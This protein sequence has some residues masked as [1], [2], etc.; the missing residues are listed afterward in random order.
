LFL[1]CRLAACKID[2]MAPTTTQLTLPEIVLRK[3][4][5]AIVSVFSGLSLVPVL[6]WLF[7]RFEW[8]INAVHWAATAAVVALCWLHVLRSH[9]LLRRCSILQAVVQEIGPEEV[10]PLRLW[11]QLKHLILVQPRA[12][13]DAMGRSYRTLTVLVGNDKHTVRWD[14]R[15]ALPSFGDSV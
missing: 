14:Y 2:A 12:T 9:L 8:W 15:K 7:A 4:F 1:L 6:V 13:L 5:L 3:Q 11:G 10:S